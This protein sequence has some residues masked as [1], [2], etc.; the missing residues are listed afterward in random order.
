M[1]GCPR[2]VDAGVWLLHQASLVQRLV[3]IGRHWTFSADADELRPKHEVLGG[4]QKSQCI[5]GE[6]ASSAELLHT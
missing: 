6:V 2:T 1:W 4:S 5:S 3:R